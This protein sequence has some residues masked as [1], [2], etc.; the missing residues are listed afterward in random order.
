MSNKQAERESERATYKVGLAVQ[1]LES[2]IDRLDEQDIIVE[3][4]KIIGLDG[5]RGDVLMIVTAR[6]AQGKVV[7]FRN[8]PD[9]AAVLRSF[10]NAQRNGS[11]V[12]KV[13]QY[14]NE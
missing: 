8:G 1:S 2:V 14:A 3:S 13:D 6:G 4:L 11:L 5:S 12:W 10:V 9:V 7:T